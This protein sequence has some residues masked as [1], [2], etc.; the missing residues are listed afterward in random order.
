MLLSAAALA[1]VARS[2]A[3]A[4]GLDEMTEGLRRHVL[5]ALNESQSPASIAA[6]A[7]TLEHAYP[8]VAQQLRARVEA[9]TAQHPVGAPE[10]P[11][12]PATPEAPLPLELEAAVAAVLAEETEPET[13]DA[14]ADALDTVS[15]LAA[16]RVRER[17]HRLRKQRESET[18]SPLQRIERAIAGWF[19]RALNSPSPFADARA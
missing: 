11:A 1:L 6:W 10:S 5:Y 12:P 17:V 18:A 14:I 19:R 4:K 7:H 16:K 8:S 2:T 13:L 3:K 15:T 9:L